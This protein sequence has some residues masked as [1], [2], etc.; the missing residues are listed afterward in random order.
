MMMQKKYSIYLSLCISVILILWINVAM[1]QQSKD[2]LQQQ[3]IDIYNVY[4][5]TLRAAAKLDLNTTLPS[6]NQNRP[7][8]IYNIPSQNLYFTYSPV[9]LKPLAMGI[10][11]SYGQLY[12]SYIKAGIGNH[13]TPL[14]QLGLSNGGDLPFQYGLNFNYLSSKGSLNNQKFSR[15]NLLLHGKYYSPSHV[16][17]AKVGYNRHG[18]RYYGYDHD[19]TKFAEDDIKQAYN[20]FSLKVGMRNITPNG[21]KLNYQPQ[22]GFT[23]FFDKYNRSE[24]SFLVDIP[25]QK[26]IVKDIYI[27]AE[28]K[29]D[30]SRYKDDD[31]TFNNSLVSIHPAVIISKDHFVLHAGVNPTWSKGKFYLLPDIVNETDLIKDKLILSSGWIAYFKKNSYQNLV[32]ENPFISDFHNPLNTR[33]VEKYTGIKGS[34]S[35]HFTYNTK[36]SFINFYDRPL[37]LNDSVYGNQFHVVNEE[38]LKAYEFH[39]ELGYA[40]GEKFR[41]KISGSWFNYF[42]Q[43]TEDK[44]WGLRPFTANLSLQYGIK[45]LQFTADLYAL[46]GSYYKTTAG[47]SQ[48]TDGVF[49]INLGGS[50]EFANRFSVWLNA[51]NLLNT[52]YQRWNQ[53]PSIG[54][55]IIGGI[56]I[57]F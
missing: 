14:I 32:K 18:I 57:K 31:S 19:T 55:N 47:T 8:L 25:L 6:S 10:D 4:Q 35:N 37:Y 51:N 2:S 53:Y 23:S 15:A 26:V 56:M 52:H 33:I 45:K 21:I 7:N 16:I 20:T 27:S 29:A 41:A 54:L 46:S 48:K 12:N 40:L 1:A 50:Y 22:L 11:T 36:F 44:P 43:T 3:T 42:E 38:E 49:D 5:P 9:P 39:A 30:L 17:H 24:T 13:S 34:I 28:L